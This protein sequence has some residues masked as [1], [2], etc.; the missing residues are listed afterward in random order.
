MIWLSRLFK[1]PK[2]PLVRV[3]N[4]RVD[5]I[6]EEDSWLNDEWMITCKYK[7]GFEEV[8]IKGFGKTKQ[9]AMMDFDNQLEMENNNE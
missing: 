9:E 3:G 5:K 8:W 2:F 6:L 1:K 4:F 7:R